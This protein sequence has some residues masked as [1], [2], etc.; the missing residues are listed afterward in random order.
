MK[1]KNRKK[2]KW[3]GKKELEKFE[4]KWRSKNRK[5]LRGE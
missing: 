5:K 2:I 4:G 3:V 1:S